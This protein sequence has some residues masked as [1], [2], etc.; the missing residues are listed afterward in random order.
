MTRSVV[1][2]FI[3]PAALAAIALIFPISLPLSYHDFADQTVVHGLKPFGDTVSNVAF[4]LAGVYVWAR[5]RSTPER[6]LAVS[7]IATCI[8]SWFYHLSPGD[9]RLLVDRLPMAPAFAA[10]GAIALYA[11][12]EQPALLFTATF[13][14]LF[15]IA[16]A[17]ALAT[18]NQAFW[19]VSQ[20]Y[21]LLIVLSAALRPEMRLAAIAAFILY[22]AAKLTETYDHQ[23]H[24]VTGF[25]SGHTLK[26]LLAGLAPIVWFALWEREDDRELARL[27]YLS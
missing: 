21:V 24:H 22:A 14:S 2:S 6:V 13:S 18:G 16:A 8:G 3:L 27:R 9:T 7:L 19:I 5:A 15:A 10:M 11:D 25:V 1:L 26:H 20:V 23:L 4:L 17:Y 12:D